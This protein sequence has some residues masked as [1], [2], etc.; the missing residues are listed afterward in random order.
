MLVRNP[1]RWATLL[2]YHVILLETPDVVS[3]D[4]RGFLIGRRLSL[5]ELHPLFLGET[6]RKLCIFYFQI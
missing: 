2:N 5:L 6:G 4:L 1:T 3:I